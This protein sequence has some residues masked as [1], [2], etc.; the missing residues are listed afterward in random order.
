MARPSES[1][2][3]QMS[4]LRCSSPQLVASSSV[5]IPAHAVMAYSKRHRTESSDV[6]V[7]CIPLVIRY[8]R[9]ARRS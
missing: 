2:T 9:R 4:R 5:A 8:S 3:A 6:L 1:L 7:N